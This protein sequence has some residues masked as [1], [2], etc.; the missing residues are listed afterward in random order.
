MKVLII[1]ESINNMGGVERILS[2][3]A[4]NLS[5]QNQV[6]VISKYKTNTSSFYDYKDI[7]VIHY[8]YDLTRNLSKRFKKN[9]LLYYLLKIVEKI[10]EC[11]QIKL[12]MLYFMM[13][14]RNVKTI[15]FGR[16]FMALEFLPFIFVVPFGHLVN[17]VCP[18]YK[19]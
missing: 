11:I 4:N 14:Y 1:D 13:E 3:I 19:C 18:E 15:V 5:N 9:S 6:Y 16:V 7:I 10:K 17:N 8:L 12:K 2:T